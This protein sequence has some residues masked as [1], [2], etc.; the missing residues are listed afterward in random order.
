YS[1]IYPSVSQDAEGMHRLFKQ[2]SFPG[3]IPSHAA[4]ET[5]G[6]INEG[7]E[8]GY[9]LSHAYG[10]AFDNPSLLV[11][12]VVGDAAPETGPLA[13]SWHSN[14]SPNPARH[15]PAPPTLPLNGYKTANPTVLARISPSELKALF[16]GYGYR[17]H[18]VEGH[19]PAAMHQLMAATLE[20][21]LDEI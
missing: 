12:C 6:S 11:A 15:G 9:A 7:G 1:E 10:A 4:P 21:V 8:L 13:T 20:T 3:G 2:F 18:Y 5:P 16:T 17:P 19:E 14:N